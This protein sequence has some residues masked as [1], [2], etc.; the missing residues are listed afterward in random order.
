MQGRI[1][2]SARRFVSRILR[3]LLGDLCAVPNGHNPY[4]IIFD[5]VEKPIGRNDYLTVVNIRKFR[6]V[7]PGLGIVAEAQEDLFGLLPKRNRRRRFVAAD[8]GQCLQKLIACRWGKDDL[9]C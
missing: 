8:I 2:Q 4:H 5:P 6:K 7:S 1:I 9:Q 3:R